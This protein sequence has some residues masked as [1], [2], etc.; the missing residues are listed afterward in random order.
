MPSRSSDTPRRAGEGHFA[1]S[2]EEAAIGTVVVGE[3][4]AVAIQFLH[5]VEQALS[6][7]GSSTSGA[8]LPVAL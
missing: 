2:N 7:A 4:Q 5:G 6:L 1:S 3:Q 8:S